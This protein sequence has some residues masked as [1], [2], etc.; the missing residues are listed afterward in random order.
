MLNEAYTQG[1]YEALGAIEKIAGRGVADYVYEKI[2]AGKA[3]PEGMFTRGWE[4]VKN[5][6]KGM[7]QDLRM[8]TTGKMKIHKGKHKGEMSEDLFHGNDTGIKGEMKGEYKRQLDAVSPDTE[9]KTKGG[10]LRSGLAKASPYAATAG[11]G[12][13][14]GGYKALKDD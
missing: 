10:Y 7:A 6:H 5:Y 12:G 9:I 11:V 1:C 14:Y 3:P 2:A 4:G 13:A 8:G